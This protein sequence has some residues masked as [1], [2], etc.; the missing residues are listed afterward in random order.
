MKFVSSTIN[1]LNEL[2]S[3]L[4]PDSVSIISQDN[5]CRVRIGITAAKAQAPM[6][7]HVEYRVMLPDHDWMVGD[8]HKLIPSVYAGIV[9]KEKGYGN[10]KAASY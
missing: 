10:K 4:G 7:M 2:A 8:R 5:K 9:K 6:V 1:N 3:F